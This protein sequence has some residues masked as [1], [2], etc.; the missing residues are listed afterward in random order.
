M[1]VFVCI[2]V[3]VYVVQTHNGNGVWVKRCDACTV[4]TRGKA[5]FVHR[6]SMVCTVY[7]RFAVLL[8]SNLDAKQREREREERTSDMGRKT[9]ERREKT[10]HAPMGTISSWYVCNTTV[11]ARVDTTMRTILYIKYN[12]TSFLPIILLLL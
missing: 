9:R 7:T 8:N 11:T 6:Y 3:C 5:V 12:N 10:C 1:C 2:L 4:R